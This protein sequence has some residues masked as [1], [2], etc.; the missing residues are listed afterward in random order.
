MDRRETIK[1]LMV[2]TFATSFMLTSCVTDDQKTPA[3]VDDQPDDTNGYGRTPDEAARDKE[4]KG[5]KYFNE[6]EMATIAILSDIIIPKEGE[7]G[8]ATEVGVPD[9]IEF[10]V[11][12]IPSHQVPMRGGLQWLDYESNRRFNKVFKDCSHDQHIEIVED[13]AYPY[14]VAPGFE[15]GATFFS[16]MRNLVSTGYF[17]S[18]DGMKDLGYVGNTPNVWDGVP[19]EVLSKHG[20]SYD[21]QWKDMYLK[22]EDRSEIMTWD[23]EPA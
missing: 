2:G 6:K 22:P 5:E 11:K 20:M 10:I 16:R 4:L 18:K 13:I 14:D 12:D 8:S 15:P 21:N 23:D 3:V 9:F 17:T 7:F 19:D 1:H